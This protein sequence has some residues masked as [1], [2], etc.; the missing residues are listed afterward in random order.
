MTAQ[1]H[2]V[3]P[4]AELLCGHASNSLSVSAARRVCPACGSFWDLQ[5][6]RASVS[7]DASYASQRSHDDPEEGHLKAR[8][9]R[10]WL[11]QL[12]L[13]LSQKSVCEVGFG[14]GWTLMDLAGRARSVYGIE[15]SEDHLS[16]AQQLGVPADR[17]FLASRLPPQFP[18]NVDLWIF[19]DSFEHLDRPRAFVEWMIPSAQRSELLIVAPE[20]GCFSERV[21]GRFWPHR[22]SDHR[23]HWSQQG[24]EFFLRP[25]G[26]F[27]KKRF[28]PAK[29]TSW[30]MLWHHFRHWAG[31][32]NE[33]SLRTGLS[34]RIPIPFNI[35]EMGLL[36]AREG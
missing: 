11:S 10:H 36:F 22:L 4:A 14:G 34:F 25:Y 24:L 31:P 23:F 26:F 9:H 5:A 16:R 15:A 29:W 33:V 35:G 2:S 6:C 32:Q 12:A 3:S 20:A 1:E 7:Y 18:E 21:M 27:L 8:T 30:K 28:Y 13:D 17:L 19:A